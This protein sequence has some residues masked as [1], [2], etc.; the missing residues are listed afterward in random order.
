[1]KFPAVF[2]PLLRERVVCWSLI[3]TGAI[4]IGANML[5][6]TLWR[7]AF[8]EL[9]G[10]PCP[11]CGLTRGMSALA[12]GRWQQAVE[13]NVGTP[14]FAFAIMLM[15]LVTLMKDGARE[16]I[17]RGVELVERRTGLVWFVLTG[18]L[19][20]GFWRMGQGTFP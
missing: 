11:G 16:P 15:V 8:K 18:L 14:V 7:C 19:L 1:M 3:A 6:I 17:L 9:T 12:H 20:W 2:A 4:L 5:G 10:R 13:W